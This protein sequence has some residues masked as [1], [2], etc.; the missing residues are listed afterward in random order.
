[1]TTP[2]SRRASGGP[3]PIVP[4]VAYGA[5]MI[6]SV[7][8]SAGGPRTTTPAAEALRYARAHTG[9]LHA[10]A[11]LAFAAALPLA[12]WTAVAY[13]QLHALGVRAPGTAMALVGG[14]LAAG[15]MALSG[16][17]SW[18][19]AESASAADP[20]L[21]RVLLDLT[22]VTGAAGFAVPFALLV[23]GIAVP[24]LLLGLTPRPVAVAGLIVAA[25][26][27]L[28]TLTLTTSTL[29][30][31]LPIVRFGGLAWIIAASM[32]LPASRRSSTA[33]QP[34]AAA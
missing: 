14:T 28:A 19:S 13:R 5:L 34:T 12:I 29:N 11:V 27:M 2:S 21:A 18:V 24:S 10:V 15:S 25:A 4:A 23:A 20:G 33:N 17:L 6:A 3:P 32:L 22:F 16:L 9:Q 31:T 26:G 7:I 8:V 1:M 30:P